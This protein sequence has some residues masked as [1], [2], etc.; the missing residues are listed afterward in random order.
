MV[1]MYVYVYVGMY[2][3]IH[4]GMSVCV[5]CIYLLFICIYI[6]T[7]SIGVGM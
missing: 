7:H 5:W 1:C 3:G 2:V 6:Y 4:V